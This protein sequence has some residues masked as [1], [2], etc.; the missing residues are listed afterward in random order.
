[1]NVLGHDEEFTPS[2]H[3]RRFNQQIL[4]ITPREMLLDLKLLIIDTQRL[5]PPDE[6]VKRELRIFEK[7]GILRCRSR[8]QESLLP[9]ETVNPV[10]L[11]TH[12]ELTKFII[13]DSHEKLHHAGAGFVLQ[14]LRREYWFS[15]AR[16]TINKRFLQ[17]LTPNVLFVREKKQDPIATR[18]HRLCR[19]SV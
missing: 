2:W 11:P 19:Q 13:S 14:D 15:G 12:A 10:Y 1:M 7:D 9:D 8:L 6:S 16:R 4:C 17:T 18:I 3:L 5:L